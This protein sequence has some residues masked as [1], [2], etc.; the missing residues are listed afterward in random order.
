MDEILACMR[1]IQQCAQQ[2]EH[3][4]NPCL[5]LEVLLLGLPRHANGET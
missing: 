3:N 1:A 5:A 4:V 2:V